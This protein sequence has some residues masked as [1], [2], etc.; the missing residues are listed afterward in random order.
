M[1]A[2]DRLNTYFLIFYPV[3]FSIF[4]VTN[5][6]EMLRDAHSLYVVSRDN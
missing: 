6:F 4:S 2:F 3:I 1:A 5:I